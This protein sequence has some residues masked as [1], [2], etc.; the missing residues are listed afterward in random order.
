MS[1]TGSTALAHS[2]FA[3]QRDDVLVALLGAA[4]TLLILY[5]ATNF[6]AGK[7][8]LNDFYREV[9]PA[10]Q[11]L[12]SGHLVG[13]IRVGPPYVGSAVLRAPFALIP[14]I[15]GGSSRQVFFA[16]ALPCVIAAAMFATWLGRQRIRADG[17]PRRIGPMMFCLLS[18]V[19]LL[20]VFGGHPEEILGGVLCVIGVYLAASGRVEWAGV[21]IGLAVINKAWALVAVPVALVAMPDRR[22]RGAAII[23]FT[24]G[25]AW[26]PIAV[27]RLSGTASNTGGM[28]LGTGIGTIFN[29][30][31][32]LWWFGRHSW[33]V[34]HSHE[35][36]VL[37]SAPC[38][39][40]W[41]WQTG[42]NGPP[43]DRVADALLLLALVLLLRAALDPLDNSYYHAPFVLALLAYEVRR[44]RTPWLALLYSLALVIVVPIKGPA[45]VS[46]AFQ[47]G[48]YAALVLPLLFWM[49]WQLF[50]PSNQPDRDAA[51]RGVSILRRSPTPGR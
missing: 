39:L 22:L 14:M 15:W 50:L 27:L 31:Q 47:A 33:L 28:A 23:A 4:G 16:A 11:A 49:S 45:H 6:G 32:L 38:A 9:W 26:I 10:Y 7:R 1:D 40:L 51:R 42:R 46:D 5:Y 17:T 2:W 36:I 21:L 37:V 13:F 24:A 19:I 8:N 3:R 43:A 30:P 34:S 41:L 35:L 48:L 20:A 29:P 44:D 12:A 18:P 25:I